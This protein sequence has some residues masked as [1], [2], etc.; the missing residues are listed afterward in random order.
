MNGFP[1]NLRNPKDWSLPPQGKDRMGVVYIH[2]LR[3]HTYLITP[4]QFPPGCIAPVRRGKSPLDIFLLP[5]DP[6]EGEDEFIR[7]S[8]I[9]HSFI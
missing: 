6:L 4:P 5:P 2:Y 8:L 9:T 7:P 3:F 1:V